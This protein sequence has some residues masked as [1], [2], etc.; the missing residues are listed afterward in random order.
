GWGGVEAG[1]GEDVEQ[2][3]VLRE[4][5]EPR[6]DRGR[7]EQRTRDEVV[8][9]LGERQREREAEVVVPDGITDV[10]PY[11][12]AVGS[13]EAAPN[14]PGDDDHG[15]H[16]TPRASDEAKGEPTAPVARERVGDDHP[17]AGG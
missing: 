6:H 9:A 15:G 11:R 4:A 16:V 14:D 8:A 7:S 5:E 12:R 1:G 3:V 2:V 10:Q 17:A 13:H